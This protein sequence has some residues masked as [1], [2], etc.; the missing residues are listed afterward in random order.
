LKLEGLEIARR[1]VEAASDRQA[2]N[3]VLLDVSSL[4]SFADYFVICS[5]ES[6]RQLRAIFDEVE[7][8]LK[9]EG[10]PPLRQE[11]SSDSGWLL[12]DYGN[13]IVHIFGAEERE[14][15][16]LDDFWREAKT[17]LNIQ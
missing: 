11:G 10:A 16:A 8:S 3:I 12:L 2:V 4:C 1:A 5:G 14:F 9:S 7:K 15:Y 17:V 13:V 6:Q